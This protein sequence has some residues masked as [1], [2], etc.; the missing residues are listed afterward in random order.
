MVDSLDI[1]LIA[2]L[3]II[4]YKIFIYLSEHLGTFHK[5]LTT[6]RCTFPDL[7]SHLR[8]VRIWFMG[9]F[10]AVSDTPI[11]GGRKEGKKKKRRKKRFKKEKQEVRRGRRKK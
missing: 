10:E 3:T 5:L 11:K 8:D 2:R 1:F 4:G 9:F 7:S 6:K